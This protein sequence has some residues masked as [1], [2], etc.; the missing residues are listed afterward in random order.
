MVQQSL[1]PTDTF[2]PTKP[3]ILLDLNFTLVGNSKDKDSQRIPYAEKIRLETYRQWLVEL[4][5]PYTVLLCTVRINAYR[6]L[7]LRLI[8]EKCHWQPHEAFFNLTDHW[9][10]AIVKDQYLR[11]HIFPKYGLPDIQPYFGIE[12]SVHT[13]A[14]YLRH[15][16]PSAPVP[17]TIAWQKL[18]FQV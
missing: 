1:F 7:T 9:R 14:M 16:I 10:G 8:N 15:G 13:R 18:P 11:D 5:R 17:E 12:S 6:G 3:I 2:Q 4:I